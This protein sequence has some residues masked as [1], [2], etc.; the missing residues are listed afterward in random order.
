MLIGIISDTHDHLDAMAKAVTKL[1]ELKVELVIHCGDFISPFVVRELGKLN[2]KLIG[3]FGNNDGDKYTLTEKFSSLG[4]ELHDG[5][6][7]LEIEGLRFL[8]LHGY[9]SPEMTINI[10]HKLAETGKYDVVAYGHTHRP[11]QQ[12]IGE[13]LVLNPGE[14]CGYLSHVSTIMVL[15]T[16]RMEV[17]K[18]TL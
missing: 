2:C 9:R 8:V 7:T 11:E 14:V 18:I 13:T 3:V 17:R 4:F 10:A 16:K 12:K 15:D 1:N 5:P 6:H